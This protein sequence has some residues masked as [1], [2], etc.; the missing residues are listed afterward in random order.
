[1]NRIKIWNI[2]KYTLFAVMIIFMVIEL[3]L[4]GLLGENKVGSEY[5]INLVLD[6]LG[7]AILLIMFFSCMRNERVHRVIVVF[8]AIDFVTFNYLFLDSLLCTYNNNPEYRLL[9]IFFNTLFYSG[10]V[11]LMWLFWR[12]VHA[13]HNIKHR[14]LSLIVN[15]V[16]ILGLIAIL[17]NLFGKY[18][19]TVSASGHYSRSDTYWLSLICPAVIIICSIIKILLQKI[20]WT[21]KTIL[22]VYPLFPYIGSAL[23]VN[24]KGP[25]LLEIFVFCSTVF[26]YSNLYV[27]WEKELINQK[28][29]AMQKSM[30]L[31]ISQ[32][33]SHFIS[34]TLI[35]IQGLYHEDMEKADRIMNIFNTYLQQKFREL[36]ST[37]P[38]S[39]E[40]ELEHTQCYTDIEMER[41]ADMCVEYEINTVDFTIPAM[42]IQPLVENAIR[43]G[44]LPLK[45]G[46]VVRVI[47]Y[48]TTNSWCVKVEDNGVGFDINNP[49]PKYDDRRKHIG[50]ANISNRLEMMVD[51]EL[52]IT[53]EVGKG[54]CAEIRIPK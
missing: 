18:Y 31:M 24:A 45:N 2:T 6:S 54:T 50:L 8:C 25:T 51:G 47:T 7:M 14:K 11:V 27:Y 52:I 23:T 44:L 5:I 40:K 10:S 20:K 48:E 3:K 33:Q 17:G 41:W 4:V 39:V 9:N 34:N 43:H 21:E 53:S 30:E 19:F 35:T 38:I 29:E 32:I 28:S 26:I 15:I 46:G 42:T 1:M 16:T 13:L 36:E 37:T 49:M 22:L 12:F